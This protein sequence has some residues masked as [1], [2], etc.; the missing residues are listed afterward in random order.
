[1]D[2]TVA[3]HG[4][5]GGGGGWETQPNEAKAMPRF[6]GTRNYVSI[7]LYYVKWNLKTET[8]VII[9]TNSV[10]AIKQH[11]ETAKSI[12][13]T[14]LCLLRTQSQYSPEDFLNQ[15][16]RR[17]FI[18]ISYNHPL[19][20]TPILS[21]KTGPFLYFWCGYNNDNNI[22]FCVLSWLFVNSLSLS[23]S[24]K[25]DGRIRDDPVPLQIF[26]L[27]FSGKV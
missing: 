4:P 19:F 5:G 7:A 13:A 24:L 27:I 21:F 22:F 10:S 12:R 18:S 1:M 20:V 6:T 16:T 11:T 2:P 9:K 8:A 15:N 14:Y 3:P 26:P 17:L 23:S 25:V